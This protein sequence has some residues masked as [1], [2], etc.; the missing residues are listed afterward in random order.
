MPALV[1]QKLKVSTIM[2]DLDGTLMHTA[3]ELARAAGRM[4]VDLGMPALA[5]AQIE[6]Y[7]GEGAAIL[8]KRCLTG[9]L[10]GEPDAALFAKAHDLF[11]YIKPQ[12]TVSRLILKPF[13]QFLQPT[14]W[15]PRNPFKEVE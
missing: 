9:E 8:I 10:D 12:N 13:M 5:Q 15:V 7:I 14:E 11:C 2:L 6:S 3:P 4:L 1:V